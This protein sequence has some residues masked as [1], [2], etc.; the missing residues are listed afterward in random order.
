MARSP[1]SYRQKTQLTF[2]LFLIVPVIL[3]VGAYVYPTIYSVA[4]SLHSWD[5]MMP[6]WTFVGLGNYLSLF[7]STRFWNSLL[8]NFRWL[9][10]YLVLPTATGLILALLLD[11]K[12]KGVSIYKV[13]FF[14]PFTLTPVAVAAI[15]KWMYQP[16]RGFVPQ[17]LDAWGLGWLNQNWLGDPAIVNYSIMFAALWWITGFSFLVYFAGLRSIPAEY[18][19]AARIDGAKPWAI[20]WQVTFPLLWPSTI[21]VLGIAGIDAMRVFDIVQGMT[22]GGPFQSSEVLATQ[23]YETSFRRFA[24]GEGAA[25]AVC[26]MVVASAVI[27]PYIIYMASRVEDVTE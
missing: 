18:I 16:G 15:W 13:I 21:I 22:M 23:M 11:E 27:L 5:G 24:M 8:N 1:I 7:N 12:L 26:L 4:M 20:F 25:I 17:I 3:F 19:E 10:F 9:A 6:N 2:V 14:L